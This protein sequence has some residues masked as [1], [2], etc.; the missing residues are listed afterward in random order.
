MQVSKEPGNPVSHKYE[1]H[2]VVH[3]VHHPDSKHDYEGPG[4]VAFSQVGNDDVRI[5]SKKKSRA[6][7][8][9]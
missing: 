1:A 2:H 3:D 9:G 7:S 6:H 4:N 5:C 8:H